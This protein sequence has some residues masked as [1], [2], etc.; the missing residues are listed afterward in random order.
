MPPPSRHL[1]TE[2]LLAS[3]GQ[4]I[5]VCGTRFRK[6]VQV[7]EDEKDEDEEKEEDLLAL[8]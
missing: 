8:V 5:S 1:G 2:A 4:I 6:P 3:R 7:Q